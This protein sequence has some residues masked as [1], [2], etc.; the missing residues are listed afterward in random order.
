MA[1]QLF[2]LIS[3]Q[4][5]FIDDNLITCLWGWKTSWSL[6]SRALCMQ[7]NGLQNLL[8][9]PC[10]MVSICFFPAQGFIPTLRG[11]VMHA[12]VRLPWRH[13]HMS[14]Y[15]LMATQGFGCYI[16]LPDSGLAHY[17][18]RT[19]KRNPAQESGPDDHPCFVLLLSRSR[20]KLTRCPVWKGLKAGSFWFAN[21][22]RPESSSSALRRGILKRDKCRQRRPTW[23]FKSPISKPVLNWTGSVLSTP[24]VWQVWNSASRFKPV[25]CD[26]CLQFLLGC[27]TVTPHQ[28]IN[29]MIWAV[30]YIYIYIEIDR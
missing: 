4:M 21:F 24:D 27:D 29:L 20:E 1:Q 22:G 9:L 2:A 16:R 26:E 3:C 12:T 18:R 7:A 14:R 11:P 15:G 28:P 19:S 5:H 30:M 17:P 25:D 10:Y 23:S 6:R 8:W 13:A